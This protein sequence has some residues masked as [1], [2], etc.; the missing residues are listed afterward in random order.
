MK[1]ILSGL[2]TLS[3]LLILAGCGSSEYR[4]VPQYTAEQFLNT[5]SI[6]GGSFSPDESHILY[7]SDE[8]GIYN[9]Y[10]IPVGG[11]E[12]N[13][14]TSSDSN[15]VFVYSYFP[16]DERFLFRSDQGGNELWHIYLRNKDGSVRDLTP[17]EGHRAIFYSWAHDDSSFYFG[18]NRRNKQFMDVYEMD[19]RTFEP[20]MVFQNDSGYSFG[21]VSNDE[22][23]I[24]LHKTITRDNSDIYLLDRET[25][26]VNLLTEHD[27]NVNY[28]PSDFSVDSGSLYWLT[29]EGSE[30][31]Y[32]QRYDI[33]SGERET[34]YSTDWDVMYIYFSRNG[35]YRVTGVNADAK[36]EIQV[37][38]TESG[39]EVDLPELPDAQISS[40]NI[41]RSE[42]IMS[43]YVNG[44]RSPNNL[45]T[46]DFT[47]GEVNQLTQS[48]NPKIDPRDLVDAQIVRYESFD[49]LEIPALLYKPHQIKPGAKAPAIV[50]VHGGP[51]GQARVGYDALNQYLVNHGYVLIDVNN[52]GSSGYGKSFYQA[53]DR[54]H[55]DE[56][57]QDCIEAKDFLAS[58]GYVD[59]SR[60]A[61]LGGS[62]G[63]Y[64]VLA[65]LT[66]EPTAFAAGVDLFG[67]SNWIR[68]LE[69]IPPWWEAQ[70]KALYQEIGN[71]KEDREYLRSISPLFHAE[72]IQRP[73]LVLQGANDPRVI[74]EESDDIVG[75]VKENNVPVEYVVFDDEGHGFRKKSNRI[76]GYI[77]IREFLDTHLKSEE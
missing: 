14:L 29:D 65:A 52:R 24:A 77:T 22:R 10:T 64:M 58:T 71:P 49:G 76:E 42:E 15:A 43:F 26:D 34:V 17:Y 68:T 55:G 20:V 13:Q 28:Y 7:S 56:D 37:R 63:G 70:R 69:S 9:A 48:L 62:Y 50:S 1:R 16:H 12:P 31:T 40:V 45:Y 38:D 72:N 75:A 3:L 66:F 44:S 39:E 33:A 5:I 2:F 23:Y 19:T 73:L 53:D 27:G 25:G 35:K 32:V 4:E 61:I 54:K 67:I 57:L 59:T 30:F 18:S 21:G 36:T 74:K 51:G 60:V 46:Y 41:A 6:G 47:T 11:G 8:P